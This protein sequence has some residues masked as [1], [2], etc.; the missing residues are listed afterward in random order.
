MK[1]RDYLLDRRT[2]VIVIKIVSLWRGPCGQE[3]KCYL[4]LEPNSAEYNTT[5][6]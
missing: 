5:Q 3:V 2:I 1:T 6:Q 4:R